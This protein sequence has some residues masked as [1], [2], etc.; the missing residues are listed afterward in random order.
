MKFLLYKV[1]LLTV[2]LSP[3]DINL[4]ECDPHEF[5]NHNKS[6]IDDFYNPQ[7]TAITLATDLDKQRG[8]DVTQDL[9]GNIMDIMIQYAWSDWVISPNT[10]SPIRKF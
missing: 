5:E 1:G 6:L 2:W 9:L 4:F 7:M 8:K 10:S 3:E